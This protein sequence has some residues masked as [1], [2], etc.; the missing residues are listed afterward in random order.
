MRDTP[1]LL[2]SQDGQVGKLKADIAKRRNAKQKSRLTEGS[3]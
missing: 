1:N 3:R 2:Y